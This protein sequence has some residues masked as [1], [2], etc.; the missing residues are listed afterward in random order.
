MLNIAT[1]TVHNPGAS[2]SWRL[3][4]TVEC[5]ALNCIEFLRDYAG[6]FFQRIAGEI[7]SF[8]TDGW[9]AAK[10]ARRMDKFML[11]LLTA[12]KKALTDG[13]LTEEVM[14]EL[15]KT[16]CGVLIG[17]AMGGMQVCLMSC[18]VWILV[19]HSVQ[20]REAH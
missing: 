18:L 13:G 14:K 12:G 2:N 3:C 10:F 1:T 15:D 6:C 8:S 7:K 16:K 4:L 11:Y 17:S 5:Q 20:L 19:T 9:V